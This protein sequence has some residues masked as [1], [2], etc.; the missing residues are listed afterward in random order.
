MTKP[1]NRQYSQFNFL[2]YFDRKTSSPVAA[3]MECSGL[4]GAEAP[5]NITLKR[6]VVR[7]ENL[8][9]WNEELRR[10]SVTEHSVVIELMAEDRSQVMQRWRLVRARIIKHVSPPF[11]AKSNDVAIEE[12]TLAY[13]RVDDRLRTKDDKAQ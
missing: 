13:E 9:R 2:V 3:F 7:S 5:A 12:L 8:A 1:G 6:G 10:Q 4:S 11:N